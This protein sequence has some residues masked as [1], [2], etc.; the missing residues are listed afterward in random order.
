MHVAMINTYLL[1][2]MLLPQ[3]SGSQPS[4]KSRVA[5][6]TCNEPGNNNCPLTSDLHGGDR[7]LKSRYRLQCNSKPFNNSCV[8]SC[9]SNTGSTNE[10]QQHTHHGAS[11]AELQTTFRLH[12]QAACAMQAD[13]A[14]WLVPLAPASMPAQLHSPTVA[15]LF[16]SHYSCKLQVALRQSA[17][18]HCG[19][20]EAAACGMLPGFMWH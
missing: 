14:L 7:L 20:A 8:Y 10:T 2:R 19:L 16:G 11:H 12:R 13:G 1:P 15:L 9:Q 3:N 18:R 4:D 5:G 6:N 17:T